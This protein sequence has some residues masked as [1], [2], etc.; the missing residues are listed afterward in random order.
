M[1]ETIHYVL[2]GAILYG[3]ATQLPQNSP[4]LTQH[5]SKRQ[6]G[7]SI[8]SVSLENQQEAREELGSYAEDNN[9]LATF[10]LLQTGG[11]MLSC[12]NYISNP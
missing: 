2:T 12:W 5:C 8:G 7:H 3:A 4:P 10:M 6:M 11:V 1:E 9:I